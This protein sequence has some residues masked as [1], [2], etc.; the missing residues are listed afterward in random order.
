MRRLERRT[1]PQSLLLRA[2]EVIEQVPRGARKLLRVLRIAVGTVIAHRPPRR[3]GSGPR[4]AH[5][6]TRAQDDRDYH[7]LPSQL[8]NGPI[9]RGGIAVA[10]QCFDHFLPSLRRP[11]R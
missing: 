9:P 6:T 5:V 4:G 10:I 11:L 8:P 7:R 3:P 1:L 2:G